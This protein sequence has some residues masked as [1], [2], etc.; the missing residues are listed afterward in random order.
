M[1]LPSETSRHAVRY[2]YGRYVARRLRRAKLGE[3]EAEVK[4]RTADIKAAEAGVGEREEV[5]QDALAD[6]DAS[7]DELDDLAK[8]H[9]RAIEGR[10]TNANRERPY[11]DLFPDGI[12]YYTA[13]PLDEQEVRYTLLVRRYEEH[14]PEGDP[15]RAE[16]G[17][18][19]GGLAG[20]VEAKKALAQAELE[21]ALAKNAVDRAVEAWETTLRRVYFRLA[22]RLGKTA[23]ERFFPAVGR[24]AKR[25][26]DGAGEV[27]ATA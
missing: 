17:L 2:A 9:R 12:A 15:V 16:A 14:L 8:R 20:W 10:D 21:V 23:A 24:R 11:I 19:T 6:R 4:A 26:T 13:A 3:F 25:E 5:R 7:D 1:R 22:E 27:E 18:L